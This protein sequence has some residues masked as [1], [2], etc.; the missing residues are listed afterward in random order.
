MRIEQWA[1]LPT[2][3]L[4]LE[5]KPLTAPGDRRDHRDESLSL[6]RLRPRT[7]EFAV[8]PHDWAAMNWQSPGFS[9]GR[10]QTSEEFAVDQ[11]YGGS[12]TLCERFKHQRPCF[13]VS[14]PTT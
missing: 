5:V 8:A 7:V 2:P 9:R 13:F 10:C 11:Q 14:R 4:W 1:P 12:T 6:I 3:D